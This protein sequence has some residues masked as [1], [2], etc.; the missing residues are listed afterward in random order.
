[1]TA[2]RDKL[3]DAVSSVLGFAA[4]LDILQGHMAH[5][6]SASKSIN[7]VAAAPDY[8]VHFLT[9]GEARAFDFSLT[10]VVLAVEDL[11]IA[12]REFVA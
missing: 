3:D 6:A 11:A 12:Y 9:P 8:R 1:M 4:V 7:G 10:G 2:A 5:N